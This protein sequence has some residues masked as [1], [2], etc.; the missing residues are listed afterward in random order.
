MF[1][2][3]SVRALKGERG[4]DVEIVA[5]VGVTVTTD[6]GKKFGMPESCHIYHF[7]EHMEIYFEM[8]QGFF[9]GLVHCR[10]IFFIVLSPRR[11]E[12]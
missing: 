10:A 1:F 9:I 3:S 7:N 6:D 2:M 5:P 11:P 4:K 12:Y 8:K